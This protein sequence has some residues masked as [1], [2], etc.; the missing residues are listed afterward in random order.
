MARTNVI[1]WEDDLWKNFY[2]ISLTHPLFE[3][4]AG[5]FSSLER[6]K[7]LFPRAQISAVCRK[8]LQPIVEEMGINTNPDL[9][10][11]NTPI[12]LINS[13]IFLTHRAVNTISRTNNTTV[14]LSQNIPVALYVVPGDNSWRAFFESLPD[15]DSYT[16][17]MS[18]YEAVELDVPIFDS[19]WDII[20][21]NSQFQEMDFITF[22]RRKAVPFV[23]DTNIAIYN[24]DDI[25]TG[26]DVRI[27]SYAVLD[28]REGPIIIAQGTHINSGA[29]IAG[30]AVV[31]ADCR[32]MP[33]TRIRPETTLGSVCR[34]GGEVEASIILGYTNKY[35]DGFLGHSYIG[36]WVNFGALTTN[37]DLKNNYNNIRVKMPEGEMDTELNKV[38][39]FVGDHTKF[40]IGSL[41]TSGTTVGVSANLFGGGLFPKYVPSF[42]W[43]S[44]S[45]GFVHYKIDKAIETARIVMKRRDKQLTESR[46]NLLKEIYN[47]Y[48]EDRT[49]FI[50]EQHSK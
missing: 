6:A 2:P 26:N 30:P 35:H 33:Y 34:I 8:Q 50:V 23:G 17:I 14:F 12:L 38:G 16:E 7:A 49:A 46:I 45:D 20:S 25:Y 40:G 9:L 11:D 32:I 4:R 10:P 3:L 39:I 37:S 42:I 18:N 44:N 22:F 48:T 24:P 15:D 41:L 19:L 29:V 27:D 47:Y 5:A 43:G 28:A 36:E 1:L 31:G 13:R 21:R